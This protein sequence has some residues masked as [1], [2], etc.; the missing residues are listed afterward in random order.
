MREI[1]EKLLK[2]VR[3]NDKPEQAVIIAIDTIISFLMQHGS[4]EVQA[5][6]DLQ[7]LG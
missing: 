2:L 6:S 5:P 1:D 3:E 7:G 4:S